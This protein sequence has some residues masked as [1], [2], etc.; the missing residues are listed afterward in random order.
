VAWSEL[1]CCN[2]ADWHCYTGMGKW[3]WAYLPSPSAVVPPY[4]VG[5]CW[6]QKTAGCFAGIELPSPCQSL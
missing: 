5:L 6:E 4:V 1:S 3:G 2:L